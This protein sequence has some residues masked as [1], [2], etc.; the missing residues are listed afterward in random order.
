MTAVNK[1]AK[2][3]PAPAEHAPL[4]I[5]NR[6]GHGIRTVIVCSCEWQP[7]TAPDRGS[8]MHVAYMAHRRSE[9]MPR[10]DRIDPVFGEGPWMGLT[11]DEWYKQHGGEGI[12]PYTGEIR[13]F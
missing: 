4:S 11:W 8:T 13:K 7:K 9:G 3:M 12:D 10:A 5:L 1:I 6:T 2:P